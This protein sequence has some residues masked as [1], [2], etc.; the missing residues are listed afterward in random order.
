MA[1][2]TRPSG[3][4]YYYRK[5]KVAGK[6]V[7]EYVGSGCHA[8]LA[9]IN[10]RQVRDRR[11]AQQAEERS[12]QER[13]DAIDEEIDSL[14]ELTRALVGTALLLSGYRQHRRQW[15]KQRHV[16]PIHR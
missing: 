8:E 13:Q 11:A 1:W 5:R 12:M 4:R 14:V 3:R 2:K 10:D 16:K 9:A 7:T 15:R 6:V